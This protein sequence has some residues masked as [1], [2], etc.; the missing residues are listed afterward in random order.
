MKFSIRKVNKYLKLAQLSLE[1]V[2]AAA[3]VHQDTVK[4]WLEGRSPGTRLL[5]QFRNVLERK[6]KLKITLDDLLTR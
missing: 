6:T 3:G 2:T 1:E 5:G 4:R